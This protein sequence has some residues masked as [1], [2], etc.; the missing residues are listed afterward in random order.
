[1]N[2]ELKS[3]PDGL[4]DEIRQI[5]D[6]LVPTELAGKQELSRKL[7][8]KGV[9]GAMA[10]IAQT[11]PELFAAI[12][13]ASLGIE[14]VTVVE[15]HTTTEHRVVE[16]RNIHGKRTE[17]QPMKSIRETSREVRLN[18]PGRERQT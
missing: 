4:L 12:L 2:N 7:P 14:G 18:R 13:L 17:V 11:S 8:V 1:M 3:L 6:Q 15:T 10:D 5:T 16:L 9:S